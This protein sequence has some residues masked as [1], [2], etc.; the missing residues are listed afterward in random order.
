MV[1]KVGV[2]VVVI[3]FSA[4][5]GG[6][7]VIAGGS[8][9][10]FGKP[11]TGGPLG[12]VGFAL[13]YDEILVVTPN[14]GVVELLLLLID[15]GVSLIAAGVVVVETIAVVPNGGVN[16]L[17]LVVG[18]SFGVTTGAISNENVAGV[19]TGNGFSLVVTVNNGRALL[20]VVVTVV[21]LTVDIGNGNDIIFS[22]VVV[23]T[24]L[25][26]VFGRYDSFSIV[27]VDSIALGFL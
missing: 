6:E 10:V 22:L 26:I 20:V 17:A 4:I 21:L 25:V 3:G 19:V 13:G 2:E 11:N 23:I 1:P 18:I 16:E 8:V 24:G 15:T 9:V 5:V 7:I 14:T 27:L 12:N